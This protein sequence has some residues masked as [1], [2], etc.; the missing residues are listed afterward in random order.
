M[1]CSEML[2]NDIIIYTVYMLSYVIAKM[3]IFYTF[4]YITAAVRQTAKDIVQLFFMLFYTKLQTFWY[5]RL[6]NCKE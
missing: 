3:K 1:H 2:K 6:G 4:T 5:I